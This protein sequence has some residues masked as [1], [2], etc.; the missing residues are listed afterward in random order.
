MPYSIYITTDDVLAGARSLA[1]LPADA[2]E[3]KLKLLRSCFRATP[4]LFTP[5][6]LDLLRQAGARAKMDRARVDDDR[7]LAAL[8]EVF[9]YPAFRA[10]QLEIIR[11]VMAG[12]DCAR[13]SVPKPT[14]MSRTSC[15]RAR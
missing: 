14:V 7:A 11:A 10:G 15:A 13:A 2:V 5:E 3:S 12:R 8:K 9:G 1:T 6:T 4:M